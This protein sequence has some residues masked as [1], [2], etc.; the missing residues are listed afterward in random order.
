MSRVLRDGVLL[1]ALLGASAWFALGI[2]RPAPAPS[3]SG[4]LAVP[5][6]R[7]PAPFTLQKPQPEPIEALSAA[8]AR[9]LFTASRRP[10]AAPAKA[11]AALDATL[12]GVLT[13]GTEKVAIVTLAGADRA[14]RLRE[15]DSFQGWSVARIDTDAVVLERNGRTE[16]LVLTYKAPPPPAKSGPKPRESRPP[17]RR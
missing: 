2:L 17:A 13:D 12:A 4:A 8:L 10:P 1:V 3:P 16:R 9:P 11:P 7:K 6:A 15:G 5:A 14:L